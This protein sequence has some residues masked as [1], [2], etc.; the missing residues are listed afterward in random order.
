MDLLSHPDTIGQP[1]R[2]LCRMRVEGEDVGEQHL[3]WIF[4]CKAEDCS[5]SKRIEVP[6]LGVLVPVTPRGDRTEPYRILA[7]RLCVLP[8]CLRPILAKLVRNLHSDVVGHSFCHP[9]VLV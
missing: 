7:T 2:F 9:H 1:H 3:L 5:V 8:E 4:C 6:S